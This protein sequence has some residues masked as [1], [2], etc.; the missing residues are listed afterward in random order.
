MI[1]VFT[2]KVFKILHDGNIKFVV[3]GG[4]ALVLHG[5]VRLTFDLDLAIS[6]DRSNLSAFLDIMKKLGMVPRV[7]VD[8]HNLLDPVVVESWKTEKGM[9]VFTFIRPD[10]PGD[11]IDMFIEDI[12][13][14]DEL[15]KEA[16]EF[17]ICMVPVKVVSLPHL[18]RMKQIAGRPQDLADLDSISELERISE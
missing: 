12:I 7:P 10:H 11:D 13:P 16:V 8:P 17:N 3:V 14:F 6:L 2:E 15:Y 5:V 18:K 4:V 9:K 1:M